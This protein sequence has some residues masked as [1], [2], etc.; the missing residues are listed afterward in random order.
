MP[1]RLRETLHAWH[2]GSGHFGGNNVEQQ[3]LPLMLTLCWGHSRVNKNPFQV[4]RVVRG[5]P[6]YSR[7]YAFDSQRRSSKAKIDPIQK[8]H[9]KVNARGLT[10]VHLMGMRFTGV[11]I[12]SV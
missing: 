12:I 9:R 7:V 3:L 11:H 8:Q 5:L 6:E 10:V 4:S 2:L 1:W